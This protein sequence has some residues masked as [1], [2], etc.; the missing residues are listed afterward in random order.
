MKSKMGDMVELMGLL[1]VSPEEVV[2]ELRRV[3]AE[4]GE[5]ENTSERS[6]LAHLMGATLNGSEKYITGMERAGT[7][8]FAQSEQIPQR[9]M[10]GLTEEMLVS[11]RFELLPPGDDK[12]FRPAKMP[13]GWTK[14]TS[15]HDMWAYIYDALGFRR[16][17]VFYKAA[18]YDRSSHMSIENRFHIRQDFSDGHYEDGTIKY[19]VL[20][21]VPGGESEALFA[22]TSE[23]KFPRPADN[24]SSEEYR[25]HFDRKTEVEAE[26]RDRCLGWLVGRFPDPLNPLKHWEKF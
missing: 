4:P 22:V 9:L 16:L 14:R 24:V 7:E 8:Q 5:I 17:S 2:K 13:E 6:P 3:P 10:H 18:F 11:L 21:Q 26:L 23:Q 20:A 15:D 12:L 1:R 19:D 25:A